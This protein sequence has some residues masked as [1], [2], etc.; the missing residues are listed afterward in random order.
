MISV[1]KTSILI[2]LTRFERGKICSKTKHAAPDDDVV[3]RFG[4]NET[5]AHKYVEEFDLDL[6]ETI[7]DC[8]DG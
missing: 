3:V 4:F 7:T 2:K 8:K 5:K 1:D 6:G